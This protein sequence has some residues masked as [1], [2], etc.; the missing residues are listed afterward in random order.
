[1]G[2][3]QTRRTGM[4]RLMFLGLSIALLAS[5]TRAEDVVEYFHQDAIGNVRAVT[6][7]AGQVIE[8]HDY[9]PF[10]EEWCGTQVCGSATPGQPKRFTGKE[11]DSETGLDYFGARYYGSRIGRFTTVDPVYTWRENLV[12]PQRWNRYAYVR[13]NPLRYVDPDGKIPVDTIWDVG[14]VLYDIYTGVKTGNWT[15]L[16]VDALA[17]AIPYVPAGASKL[18]HL[19]KVDEVLEAGKGTSNIID[20]GKAAKGGETP[21]TA[22]GRRAHAEEP[23]PPGFERESRLP[24]GKRMDGYNPTTK[25]VIEIKPDNARATRRGQKQVE[26]YCKECDQTQGPGHTGRVQTYDPKKYLEKK[27]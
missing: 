11:R 17:A 2:G 27:E 9:L 18:R 24:S 5:P 1:M 10:G 4:K 19:G 21:F 23:L 15:D 14:N 22:A 6:N 16:G 13:N 3:R 25:E 12:D 7:Q 26:G 20:A 8:R